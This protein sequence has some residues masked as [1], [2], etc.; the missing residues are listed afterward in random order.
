MAFERTPPS[1]PQ[2]P[3]SVAA[4][5]ARWGHAVQS[6]GYGGCSVPGCTCGPSATPW[7]Y[8]IGLTDVGQPELVVLGLEPDITVTLVNEVASRRRAGLLSNDEASFVH[9]GSSFR[10]VDVPDRWYR[11]DINRMAAWFTH[12]ARPGMSQRALVVQQIVWPDRFGRFPDDP[13]A[14]PLFRRRQPM[15]RDRPLSYP[16]RSGRVSGGARRPRRPRRRR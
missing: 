14:D 12:Y 13:E 5:I 1:V 4:L 10:L 16:M 3:F 9:A 15:L 11:L 8:S 6:V 2:D 7:T